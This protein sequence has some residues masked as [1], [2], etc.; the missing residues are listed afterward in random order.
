MFSNGILVLAAVALVLIVAFG[1][2]LD[3]L[4]ALYAIGVFTGFSLAGLGMVVK[5]LKERGSR[6]RARVVVNGLSSSVTALVVVIF[7]VVKFNEGA[8]I[9][10]VVGPLMYFGLLRINRQYRSESEVFDHGG[11]TPGGGGIRTRRII[12]FVDSLDVAT[13]RALE[14]CQA[15]SIHSV[16]AVHFDVDPRVT[17]E[18]EDQ[19]SRAGAITFGIDL[20]VASCDDRRIDRAAL[21]VVA[22]A[23]RDPEVFC[24]VLLPRRGLSSRLGR[25]LHDRT[26]DAI[27]KAVSHVPRTAATIVPYY[28]VGDARDQLETAA[29]VKVGA[30]RPQPHLAADELLE[31]KA[32]EARQIGSLNYRERAQVA[33]R[34]SAVASSRSDSFVETRCTLSD[35]TGSITLVFQGRASVPG[36]DRGAR[37]MVSGMV[38]A[39]GSDA[40]MLNPDYEIVV[41]APPPAG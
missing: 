23:V 35:S 2:R 38:G 33:G 1:A 7:L 21:E 41:P 3:S 17:R 40:V 29:D 14:Y 32:K 36:L 4:I 12:I 27:S 8:W 13:E 34:I 26:A 9:I 10:A 19:W 15:L 39:R 28:E 16:R 18:L 11:G 20:E 37:L 22:D 31:S 5:H 24:M 25:L 30:I 6:W